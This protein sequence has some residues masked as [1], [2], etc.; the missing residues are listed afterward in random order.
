MPKAKGLTENPWFK[1]KFK[2]H[3]KYI[4]RK[5][6]KSNYLVKVFTNFS[7]DGKFVDVILCDEADVLA[8]QEILIQKKSLWI[9]AIPLKDKQIASLALDDISIALDATDL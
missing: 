1:E 3:G 9:L 6:D 5:K 2:T 8:V 7:D 4:I